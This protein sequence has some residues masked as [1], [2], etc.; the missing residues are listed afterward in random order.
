MRILLIPTTKLALLCTALAGAL[1]MF[2][3]SAQALS[4]RD[5][6]AS[7]GDRSRSTYVNHLTD[8]AFRSDEGSSGQY[9][10]PRSP[11]HRARST[12]RIEARNTSGRGPIIGGAPPKG[13]VP[14]GGTTAMLLGAALSVLGVARRYIKS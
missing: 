4:I 9:L 2:S 14:D 8:L 3:H 12:E 11:T 1:L 5:A 10:S 13:T 6:D 7:L